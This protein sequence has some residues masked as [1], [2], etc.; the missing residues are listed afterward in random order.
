V[1]RQLLIKIFA[2]FLDY[3]TS[4]RRNKAQ[5]WP[6]KLRLAIVM[7]HLKRWSLVLLIRANQYHSHQIIREQSINF[8]EKVC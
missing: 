5:T 4:K 1:I 7:S 8:I 2:R 3:I 6:E